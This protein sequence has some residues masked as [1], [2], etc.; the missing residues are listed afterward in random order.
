MDF[1]IS[2][3]ATQNLIASLGLRENCDIILLPGGAKNLEQLESC[4]ALSKNLHE[5]KKAILTIHE[6]CGAGAAKKDLQKAKELVANKFPEYEVRC[7]VIN[8]DG[9]WEEEVG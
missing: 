1:R 2:G 7:Y 9:S 4:L 5:S 8:L 3:E 6:D